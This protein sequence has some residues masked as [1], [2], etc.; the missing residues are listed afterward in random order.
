MREKAGTR[1]EWGSGE[2]R[3]VAGR[4]GGGMIT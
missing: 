3:N 1:R 4:G 2:K